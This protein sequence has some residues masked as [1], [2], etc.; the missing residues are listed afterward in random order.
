ML[1]ERFNGNLQHLWDFTIAGYQLNEANIEV[2]VRDNEILI[3]STS[4]LSPWGS[5]VFARFN[6]ITRTMRNMVIIVPRSFLRLNT[7]H[8]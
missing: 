5:R 7:F 6:M 8:T 3:R 1:I 2:E 4:N